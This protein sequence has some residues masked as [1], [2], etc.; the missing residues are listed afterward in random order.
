MIKEV[1]PHFKDFIFNWDYKFQFL[2]GGYGS[3]K[4]YHVALKILLKALEEKRTIL[5]V[6]NVFATLKDS[7]YSLFEEIA[8]DLEIYNHMKFTKSPLEIKLPNGSRIIF[9]GLDNKEKLKSIHNVSMIWMEECSESD[10]G[11]FKELIGRLRHPV[12]ELYFIL[13]SNPVGKNNWTYKHFFINQEYN[14][15]RLDDNELYKE[16]IVVLDNTYYHHSTAEDNLFLPPA[17]LEQLE[18]IQSYDPDLYRI[19]RQG[20]FGING[21]RVLPQFQVQTHDDVIEQINRIPKNMKKV[22]MDFGFITSYNCL[23][24]IAIDHDNKYLY[25]YYEYYKRGMTDDKTVIELDEFRQTKELIIADSAE[26][27]SIEYYNQQGF[28]MVAAKKGAGSVLEG[29]KKIKRFKKIICSE[30]CTNVIRELEHLTYKKDRHDNVIEDEFNI[31]SHA[32]DSLRY[33]MEDYQVSDLKG[34]TIRS[35]DKRLLGL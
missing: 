25:I 4:S 10:Y 9:R 34:N 20:R 35:I 16:R 21:I 24:R 31:D 15:T 6:R 32:M 12:L 11:A 5:V 29:I 14:I 27:K 19:A 3:S 13:S 8:I 26:P 33:A 2:V 22:G 30:N 17:Y 7:C 28:R 23:I 1:N 18:D